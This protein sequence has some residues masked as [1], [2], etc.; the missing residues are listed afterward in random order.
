MK[1]ISSG[2]FLLSQFSNSLELENNLNIELIDDTTDD[3]NITLGKDC[4]LT[5]KLKVDYSLQKSLVFN[6]DHAAAKV[7]IKCVC[8]LAKG[9]SCKINTLQHHKAAYTESSLIINAVLYEG[10]YFFTNNLIKIEKDAHGASASEQNKNLI[11]GAGARV[12][13]IPKLE[14]NTNDVS[15]KHG[16]AIS[17][18]KED[19]L[20]YL[21]SRGINEEIA[22]KILVDAFLNQ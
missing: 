22:K 11:L 9:V 20:F 3:V 7:N 15:A 14:I 18:I 16:A 17:K 6:L 13:S 21:K 4:N 12:V 19:H 5:Y 2:T 1:L 8:E 10:A